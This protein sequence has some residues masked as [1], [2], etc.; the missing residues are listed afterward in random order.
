MFP[1]YVAN[2][3]KCSNVASSTLRM[4]VKETKTGSKQVFS[5]SKSNGNILSL[6]VLHATT[7]TNNKDAPDNA[8]NSIATPA[9]AATKVNEPPKESTNSNV[10]LRSCCDCKKLDQNTKY[11]SGYKSVLPK[12]TKL[13]RCL[14][15]VDNLNVV[16]LYQQ[17]AMEGIQLK[18]NGYKLTIQGMK[19]KEQKNTIVCYKEE[20]ILF[21][22][23]KEKL[24]CIECD[25]GDLMDW[26]RNDFSQID[27]MSLEELQTHVEGYQKYRIYYR[28]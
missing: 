20:L 9:T 28:G 2:N 27:E 18:R 12:P 17:I 13:C 7:A 15:F 25:T 26:Y 22:K 6:S 8:T 4:Q 21:L 1:K 5:T 23:V 3:E 24:D 16:D 19:T 14:R 11:C 10:A